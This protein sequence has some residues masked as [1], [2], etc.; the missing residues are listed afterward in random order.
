MKRSPET[1][2]GRRKKT[3]IWSGHHF[4]LN[5]QHGATP[6][7]HLLL[8]GTHQL[9]A[10]G[11]QS[12]SQNCQ[13]LFLSNGVM[14]NYG[15][16][17]WHL[18]FFSPNGAVKL[19]K[20]NLEIHHYTH[21]TLEH[22]PFTRPRDSKK[23]CPRDIFW[24]VIDGAL[25]QKDSRIFLGKTDFPNALWQAFPTSLLTGDI[26][27]YLLPGRGNRP[28]ARSL[29]FHLKHPFYKEATKPDICSNCAIIHWPA[30]QIETKSYDLPVG[31][32]S[33]D[34]HIR[35]LL[36]NIIDV[37]Q[38]MQDFTKLRNIFAQQ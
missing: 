7:L 4:S 23:E 8:E 34:R 24:K 14:E 31:V 21:N 12:I 18:E 19:H 33:H 30:K 25:R 15:T 6:P 16:A 13:G 37:Y 36:P 28:A 22:G 17:T 29:H 5:Y 20:Q 9:E 3:R 26:M 35:T 10:S 1:R 11:T 38:I 32:M 27:W 2:S